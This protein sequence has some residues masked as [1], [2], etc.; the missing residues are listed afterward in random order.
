MVSGFKIEGSLLLLEVE[1]METLCACY[2]GLKLGKRLS[3]L[4]L[5]VELMETFSPLRL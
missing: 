4:L 2:F 3:L 5:E 1:L